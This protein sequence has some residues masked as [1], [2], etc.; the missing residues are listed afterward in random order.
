MRRSFSARAGFIV[1]LLS[2]S[3]VFPANAEPREAPFGDRVSAAL[4]NYNRASPH[5]ASAGV[6][7]QGG[8]AEARALGFRT[9]ID[10]RTAG[11]GV[12]AEKAEAEAL[13]LRFINIP[14]SGRAPTDI[15]VAVF[16]AI[17]DDP[18]N[19]PILVHC[20]KANRV[21][22]MW[23]LYRARKNVPAA[24]ALEEGQTLGLR[25]SRE[26]AVRKRLGLPPMKKRSE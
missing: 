1:V 24:V 26:P 13:G 25:P 18:E 7:R 12:P 20:A 3:G 10:L 17:A 22:A 19:R 16:T 5:I 21:G 23:A 15:Q 6:L 11:E 8:V 2:L 9:I 4:F 14:V